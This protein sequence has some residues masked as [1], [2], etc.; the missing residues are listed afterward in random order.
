[1]KEN[2]LKKVLAIMLSHSYRDEDPV[3]ETARTMAL[4]VLQDQEV[5]CNICE[6]VD[7]MNDL[8]DVPAE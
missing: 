1:M 4:K 8:R 6:T 2:F 7:H 5:E 3:H